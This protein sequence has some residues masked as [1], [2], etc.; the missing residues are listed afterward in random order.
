MNDKIC[1]RR[2]Y[3]YIGTT[4]FIFRMV[5]IIKGRGVFNV[6]VEYFRNLY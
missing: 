1:I 5:L 6:I 2:T 4:C 3:G